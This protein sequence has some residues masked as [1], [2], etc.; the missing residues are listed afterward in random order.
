MNATKFV[1]TLISFITSKTPLNIFD[2]KC[3]EANLHGFFSVHTRW[4]KFNRNSVNWRF[5]LLT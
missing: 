3:V 4:Q 1:S 2:G 5:E